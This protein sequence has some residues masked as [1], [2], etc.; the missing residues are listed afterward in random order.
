MLRPG[1]RML[2]Q[3]GMKWPHGMPNTCRTRPATSSTLATRLPCGSWVEDAGFGEIPISYGLVFGEHRPGNLASRLTGG[4]DEIRL[5]GAV[6]P[7][8]GPGR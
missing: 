5:V 1:G 4:S 6:K 8:V 2:M 7:E 3:I